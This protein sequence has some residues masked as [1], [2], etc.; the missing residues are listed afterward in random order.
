MEFKKLPPYRIAILNPYLQQ[1]NRQKAEV[2]AAKRMILS[3]QRIGLQVRVF[4]K[5]EQLLKYRPNVV[6]CHAYQ[7]A[8]LTTFPTYG[9]LTMPPSWGAD[10]RRFQRNILTYD[11]YITIAPTVVNYVNDL[12]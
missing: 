5:S 6:L 8:K 12:S 11:A 2:E 9:T 7:D 1:G 10:P 3:G 4:S